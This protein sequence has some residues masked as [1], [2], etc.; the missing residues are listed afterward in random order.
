M[1]NQVVTRTVRARICNYSQARADLDSH[2]F[3]AST[4][5]N[6]RRWTV[7]RIWETC[8]HIPTTNELTAYLKTHERDGDLHSQSSQQVLQ[9]LDEAFR[10][11]L[12]KRKNCDV[13][14]NPLGYRR[15]GDDH[16]RSTVTFKQKAI[17]HDAENNRSHL[18]KGWN[19]KEH[20]SDFI[21]CD[22]DVIGPTKRTIEN[23]Q[24][25]RV[26]IEHGIWRPH[27]VCR[28][29]IEVTDPPDHGVA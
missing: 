20:R 5:W 29:E 15:R 9:E 12:G 6:V 13:R 22:Y 10:S 1:A 3:A 14:A 28:V 8:G 23:V 18:S 24:Q 11:W 19:V 26:V 21:R 17:K 7:Q 27:F 4:L 16:P 2:G 25:V